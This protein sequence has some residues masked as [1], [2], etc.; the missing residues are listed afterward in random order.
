MKYLITIIFITLYGVSAFAYESEVS[1]LAKDIASQVK[2]S[3]KT[4]VAVADFTDLDGNITRLGRFLSEEFSTDLSIELSRDDIVIYDRNSLKSILTEHKLYSTRLTAPDTIK[5]LGKLAGVDVLIT[6]MLTR[7]N[8]D[9]RFTVKILDTETARI[10]GSTKGEI[11]NTGGIQELLDQGII[12]QASFQ[13]T[14]AN[15]NSSSS[16][17]SFIN[18]KVLEFPKIRIKVED[19]LYEKGN[20]V[21]VF[22]SYY[23]K[24][25]KELKI[26][27]VSPYSNWNYGNRSFLVDQQGNR[28][29]FHSGSGL[30]RGWDHNGNAWS[31]G[32]TWLKITKKNWVPVT[33]VFSNEK[34]TQVDENAQFS[35]NSEQAFVE[36]EKI[37]D[38]FSVTFKG[39]P[40]RNC[41][42]IDQK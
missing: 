17:P 12:E 1:K 42:I 5:Q 7:F 24:T 33:L 38:T 4:S 22:L 25:D 16:I 2:S 40:C 32:T 23:N 20:R 39:I 41:K 30:N 27:L 9:I 37:T 19:L 10:F 36:K 6:G 13:T 21:S 34:V 29:T 35:L 26:G 28:F 8:D 11:P 14:N 15:S 18:N 31:R 3:K